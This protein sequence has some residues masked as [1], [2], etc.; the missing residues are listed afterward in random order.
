MKR[1]Q[2]EVEK[3]RTDVMKRAKMSEPDKDQKEQEE[4]QLPEEEEQELEQKKHE[5]EHEKEQE[6]E[7]KQEQEQEQENNNDKPGHEGAKEE[8]DVTEGRSLVHPLT[9]L[10]SK[11]RQV[12]VPMAV[13]CLECGKEVRS[14]CQGCLVAVYCGAACQVQHWQQHK[15]QCSTWA[16]RLHRGTGLFPPT[17]EEARALDTARKARERAR[18][19]THSTVL[20]YH[21]ALEKC[22]EVTEKLEKFKEEA[23]KKEE[24]IVQMEDE[25]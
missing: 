23:V 10:V 24:K 2:G 12:V 14:Y 21:G 11:L 17:L 6:Q 16:A 22:D 19:K 5:K 13:A 1:P 8:D 4:E 9:K 20:L 18:D 3:D 15:E 7:Q 25:M